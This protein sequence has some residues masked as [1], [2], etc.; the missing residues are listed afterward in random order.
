MIIYPLMALYIL[1]CHWMY[2]PNPI[3]TAIADH[4][5]GEAK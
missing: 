3:V 2:N 4:I 5:T 1:Y